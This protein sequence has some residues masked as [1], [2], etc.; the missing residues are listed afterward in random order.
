MHGSLSWPRCGHRRACR[1][2]P[3]TCGPGKATPTARSPSTRRGGT[4]GGAQNPRS[5]CSPMKLHRQTGLWARRDALVRRELVAARQIPYTAQVSEHLV[6]TRWGDY[7][8]VLRLG[9]V[10]FESAD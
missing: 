6:R 9:G 3:P 8:Q 7:V 2:W 1:V 4:V 10:S 5:T